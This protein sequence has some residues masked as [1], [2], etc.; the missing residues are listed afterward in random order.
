[1]SPR[2]AGG[3]HLAT[4]HLAQVP[5]R[6]RAFDYQ[7]LMQ[8]SIRHAYF[9]GPDGGGELFHV[10]STRGARA[11]MQALGLLFRQERDGF[12]VLCDIA[13]PWGARTHPAAEADDP[14]SFMLVPTTPHFVAITD[15]DLDTSPRAT[16]FY[17]SNRVPTDGP[18]PKSE[19][20]AGG[21]GDAP[22]EPTGAPL[23]L[24]MQLRTQ[25]LVAG[26]L[27]QV[28]REFQP[29]P[30]GVVDLFPHG[31]DLGGASPLPDSDADPIRFVRYEVVFEARRTFWKYHIVP[32]PGSG[33]LDNLSI[34]PSLF[35][36]PFDETLTNGV[37]AHRFLSKEP[38]ALSSHSRL[39]FALSGRRKERMT[40]DAVL[41]DRLPVAGGDQ[42]ALLSKD[43]LAQVRVTAG[44]CS[45]MFVYV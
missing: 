39:H 8:V 19:R 44:V 4:G 23:R 9:T 34:D 42:C 35:V 27:V 20:A 2:P 13:Q 18:Q 29:I 7:R 41:M 45:E 14:L 25:P 1:M 10:S 28:A 30:I 16:P 3:T 31:P 33:P 26:R 24:P 21:A 12:S 17:F 40:R 15:M 37:R 32:Q 38:I 22:D 43:D 5:S 6:A 36:G 11:R